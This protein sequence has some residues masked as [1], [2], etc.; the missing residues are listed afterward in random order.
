VEESYF[1][2]ESAAMLKARPGRQ[3]GRVVRGAAAVLKRY[4]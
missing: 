1:H 4:Q 3:V 2:K